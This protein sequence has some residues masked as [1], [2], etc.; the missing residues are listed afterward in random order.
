MKIAK[1]ASLLVLAGCLFF[2][3]FAEDLR[4]VD[5][6][7]QIG[8]A[9]DRLE[10]VTR[11]F[12]G[13]VDA[14]QLPGAVVLIARNDKLAYLRA[15]GYQ[16][17]EKQLAMQPDSIF[18]IASMTKPVVSVAA[19]TLVE[20]AKLDLWA[21]VSQYLPEFKD[22]QVGVEHRDPGTGESV[23]AMEPP[24]RPMM[25]QD[26]L[27]HTAG[28]VYPQFGDSLVHQAYRAADVQDRNQTLEEMVA[29]LA[30]L[31]L[32]HQ[33]GEVWEYSMAADVLGRIIEVVSGMPLDQFVEERITKPLGMASSGF[34][35]PDAQ[36]GRLAQPQIDPATGELPPLPDVT[37]KPRW[38]SGGSGMVSTAGD[39]LRFCE[40]LL[41]GG[42]WEEARLLAP[43]TV[44]LMTSDALPPGVRYTER[45][46][47]LI[48]DISPM[49]AMGQGF[50][51]GFAV[52]TAEGHNPLPGSV[53]TFYWTGA[54]GTTFWVDP[55]EN[56][57]AIM[58]I[59]VPLSNAPP[60]RRA[61]RYLT[62]QALLD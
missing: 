61:I 44:R 6:P 62:Y 3:A 53:G 58:M 16:D 8:F 1:L 20:E 34:Y 10:R 15:F 23:L 19:M 35:V 40:M 4:P 17:R 45:S 39:Y 52:R 49:P 56:L 25:V 47:T 11:T 38:L 57:I 7:R 24:K 33:P 50:G 37:K 26:L 28:L 13:Y 22:V 27:R 59:Q 46:Q 60:Y 48:S 14:G 51:L 41:H 42:S 36:L 31:P 12:Q 55:K 21:P 5:D 54:W 43:T 30:R 18:R 9:A 2:P 32:A 29:K